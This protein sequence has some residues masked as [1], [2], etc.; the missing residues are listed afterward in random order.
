MC[1]RSAVEER[2]KRGR[3]V[4]EERVK[5]GGV[6]PTGV[7]VGMVMVVVGR[8]LGR[9]FGVSAPVVPSGLEDKGGMEEAMGRCSPVLSVQELVPPRR[10]ASSSSVSS[11]MGMGR[12][13]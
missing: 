3:S 6:E 2:E 11:S 4:A 1:G 13:F 8:D 12:G 9:G 10:G 7:E 5:R